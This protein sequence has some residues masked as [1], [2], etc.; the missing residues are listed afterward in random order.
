MLRLSTRGKIRRS[1]SRAGELRNA[2]AC[3]QQRPA[4]EFTGSMTAIDTEQNAPRPRLPSDLG[5]ALPPGKPIAPTTLLSAV[6]Q[7]E[8][9]CLLHQ[10]LA[11]YR[12]PL[13]QAYPEL[14]CCDHAGRCILL[15]QIV[16]PGPGCLTTEPLE[17][18]FQIQTT[19]LR[20]SCHCLAPGP[21]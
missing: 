12:H 13:R 20:K 15:D 16:N 11:A 4:A 14:S 19:R 7:I 6:P 8:K 3:R 5:G 21:N 9:H 1:V 17:P 2:R 18:A 10:E